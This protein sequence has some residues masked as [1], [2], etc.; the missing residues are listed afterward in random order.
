M[1]KRPELFSEVLAEGVGSFA[2]VFAGT[3]AGAVMV[4]VITEGAITH[5]GV[6]FVFGVVVAAMIYST[7]ELTFF[8]YYL[9]IHTKHYMQ[10][11][12]KF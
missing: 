6:S 3:G 10:N 4:N 2:L 8:L 1:P 9:L 7:P 11:V 12:N 5:L